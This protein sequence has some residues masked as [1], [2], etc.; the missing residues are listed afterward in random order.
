[1][2]VQGG[3]LV[4]RTLVLGIDAGSAK[5][6]VTLAEIAGG[7]PH[8]IGVGLAPC[9]GVRKGLVVDLAATAGAIH[10]AAAK[11]CEM[12][13]NPSV[14]RSVVSVS[15]PH[16]LSLTGSAEVAITRPAQGVSPEDIRRVLDQAAAVALAPQ[17]EVIHVVPRSYRVDGAEGVM[18][19]LGLAGRMLAAEAHLITGEK[20]P[21]RNHFRAV[22]E[23]GLEVT[24]YQLGI[25]AAGAAVLSRQE[26]EAG[27]LLLDIGA[28]TTAVA[29]YDRGYLWHVSV[30]PV[31]GAHITGDIASLLRTPVATAEQLKIERGWAATNLAPDTRFELPTPS[32]LNTREVADRQLAAIIDSRVQ[33]ILSLA[34]SEVKQSG[35]AGLFPAGLVLTGGG[36][37]LRGLV[38]VAADCLN[39]ATRLGTVAGPVAAGPEFATA[40]G[41]V[42]FGAR[43][44][45]DEVAVAVE[46]ERRA[47]W[48]R[49]KDWFKGLFGQQPGM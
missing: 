1:L 18:E 19:P 42:Y 16:I 25:R 9:Q 10:E 27:V 31:G 15:G 40:A 32:G 37:Q 41:L 3:P 45:T 44:V 5:V 47:P 7:E 14:I 13:G 23:A 24:D 33:E 43:Q 46:T 21:L 12:A 28:E 36:S 2:T 22:A 6:A 35:Y 8:I 29:V 20:L 30:I 4:E 26:K 34:A 38:P 49:I 39:L 48:T 17:R 11:A